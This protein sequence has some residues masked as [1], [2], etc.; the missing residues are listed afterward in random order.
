MQTKSVDL[1][2]FWTFFV[3]HL[4]VAKV[5]MCTISGHKYSWQVQYLNIQ[6]SKTN[7]W[8]HMKNNIKSEKINLLCVHCKSERLATE[9][10]VRNK[11]LFDKIAINLCKLLPVKYCETTRLKLI[12]RNTW[13]DQPCKV[14]YSK[15]K[16]KHKQKYISFSQTNKTVINFE[17]WSQSY[18]KKFSLLISLNK[19][20]YKLRLVL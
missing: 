15:N 3:T 9:I 11:E 5:T 7:F 4:H 12:N 1:T 2:W 14:Y 10:C 6:I 13:V 18:T 19:H 8:T 16:H 20:P 17:S